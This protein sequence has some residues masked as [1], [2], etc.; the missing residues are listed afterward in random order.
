MNGLVVGAITEYRP[1]L[2]LAIGLRLKLLNLTDG[3]LFGALSIL[4]ART[5]TS[6]AGGAYYHRIAARPQPCPRSWSPPARWSSDSPPTIAQ[7]S[8]GGEN[9]PFAEKC[10]FHYWN[11]FSSAKAQV[12][13][14][15]RK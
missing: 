11:R 2:R 1:Y 15:E 3:Q 13:R 9:S 6:G 4:T 5:G 10:L 14:I 7:T 8:T 12:L